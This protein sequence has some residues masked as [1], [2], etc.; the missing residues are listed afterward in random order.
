MLSRPDI[1]KTIE[2]GRLV[3]DPPI[4]SS[5][6]RQVSVDLFLGRLF[7]TFKE[8]PAWVASIR[9]DPS[10]WGADIWNHVKT[11]SF[12][13]MPGGFVLARTLEM[14]TLPDDLAGFVEG[15]SS[16]ARIGVG[17]HVTAPKI[18][19]GFRGSITLE[20][21]NHG[22]FPVEL[23]AG[24]DKPAQLML[25]RTSQALESSEVYGSAPGDV[26]QYQNRPIPNGR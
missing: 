17:I 18:D 21:S 19:P 1:L 13:L 4:D 15:R 7:T 25:F 20:M 24:I 5:R 14:V 6:I 3:F 23:R 8:K 10:I 26:F 22:K 11:D 9:L 2:E 16:Y 12:V